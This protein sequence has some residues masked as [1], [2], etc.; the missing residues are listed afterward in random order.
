MADQTPAQTQQTPNADPDRDTVLA[1]LASGAHRPQPKPPA[2]EPKVEVAPPA[3]ESEADPDETETP[4][5]EP[6]VEIKPDPDTERRL[7]TIQKEQ[8]AAA[9]QKQEAA[10]E[11]K[12]LA[13][14]RAAWQAEQKNAAAEVEQARQIL[15]ML[16]RDPA[17]AFERLGIGTDRFEDIGRAFYARSP[18]GAE[19]PE[20]REASERALREREQRDELTSLREE[21]AEFKKSQ[22]AQFER[23]AAEQAAERHMA[24][25]FKVARAATDAPFLS[26]AFTNDPDEAERMVYSIA[27]DLMAESGELPDAADIV[28]TYEK[29]Q[30]KILAMAGIDVDAHLKQKAPPPRTQDKAAGEKRPARTLSNDLTA[31][32]PVRQK[33]DLSPEEERDQ[34]LA[35][36]AKLRAS[37]GLDSAPS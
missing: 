5:P 33:V 9:Q 17:G 6:K 1:E 29:R 25:V 7:A 27:H 3:E 22:T 20:Y 21:V 30:R 26:A 32:T 11:R 13:E 12:R 15:G 16:K 8:K 24:G 28:A 23:M 36:M 37:G 18:K 35:E 34:I 31:S 14:E 19:K 4:A 2:A 10:A